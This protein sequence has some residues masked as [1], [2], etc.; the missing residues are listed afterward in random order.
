MEAMIWKTYL[1]CMF[2]KLE[3]TLCGTALIILLY[4]SSYIQVACMHVA[5]AC[6]VHFYRLFC[7]FINSNELLNN[8]TGNA[9]GGLG[10]SEKYSLGFLSHR[11]R[12]KHRTD[13][14]F[15]SAFCLKKGENCNNF[16]LATFC[17]CHMYRFR[18]AVVCK[19]WF[20]VNLTLM[21]KIS[22]IFSSF[23]GIMYAF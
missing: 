23:S 7:C 5:S 17:F 18:P 10:Y 19:S 11:L 6:V 8:F 21:N 13:V 1:I 3:S 15:V 14:C 4:Q 2:W 12:F 9:E 16:L 20:C 22:K